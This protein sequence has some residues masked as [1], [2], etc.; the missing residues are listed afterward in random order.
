MIVVATFDN[1]V[2]AIRKGEDVDAV[3]TLLTEKAVN[4]SH[5]AGLKVRLK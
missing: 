1:C 3:H 4:H 2:D 5:Q